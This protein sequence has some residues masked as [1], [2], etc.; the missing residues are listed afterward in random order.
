MARTSKA[1]KAAALERV[2]LFSGLSKRQLNSVAAVADPVSFEPGSVLVKELEVG[3]RLIVI[4]EGT[5]KVVRQGTVKR[6]GSKGGIQPGASRRL[7]TVG[8]GDVV[9]ELSLIDGE[10]TSASV[11]AET[12]MEVLVVDRS[13]FVKLFDSVPQLCRRLLVGLAAKVRASDHRADLTG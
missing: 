3:Q 2:P 1:Q 7:G 11:I 6:A 5:A 9:G 4:H 13:S 12:A 8:P 10:P